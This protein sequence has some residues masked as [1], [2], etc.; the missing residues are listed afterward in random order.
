M[1]A[2]RVNRADR[3]QPSLEI[4]DIERQVPDEHR[5]RD[6]WAFVET[7]DLGMLYARIK[8]RGETPGRPAVDPRIL[9]AL[10]LYATIDGV[11]SARA[12]ARLC[13]YHVIYRWICGGVGVNHDL[14]R[15]FRNESGGF[16]DQLLTQSLTALI[17]EGLLKLDEMITDGTKIRASASRSSMRHAPRVAEIETRL[18]AHIAKLRAEL[19]ADP[20]AT[21][22]RLKTRQ[23]AAAEERERRVKAAGEK[24]AG[25]AAEQAARAKGHPGEAEK[26]TDQQ[27]RVSTSDPDARLMKMADGA[28]RPCYNV[29]VATADE[30]VVAIQ[31]T[32]HGNDRGLARGVL[33][34]VER[35]CG[36]SPLRLLADAT[37]MTEDDIT[38]FAESHPTLEVFAP[39]KA[40]SETAK[41]ASRARYARKLAAEPQCLKDWRARM[42][43]DA[44]KAVYARRCKTE[45]PHARMKNCGLGRMAVRGLKKVRAVCLLHAVAH[46]FVLAAFRRAARPGRAAATA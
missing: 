30:F 31:P 15:S 42:A 23:L 14:L 40:C 16:L 4:V 10:W 17:A 7:L 29:Q 1:E 25:R 45:H 12:L 19:D 33:A 20:A 22:R 26:A 6:V 32:E 18:T 8:A 41:P 3:R 36:R 24:F 39:P 28:T 13:E 37:A 38:A 9:L 43:S 46:N 35:R 34:E 44:G 2:A 27:P 5:V 11:G 21:E